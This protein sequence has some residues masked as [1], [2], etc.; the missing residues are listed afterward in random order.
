MS[1]PAAAVVIPLF[2]KGASWS[3]SGLALEIAG[4]VAGPA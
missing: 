2:F 1:P 4:L 3:G